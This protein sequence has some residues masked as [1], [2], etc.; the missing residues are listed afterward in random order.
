MAHPG[1]ADRARD[2]CPR[3]AHPVPRQRS[4]RDHVGERGSCV[5]RAVW[6]PSGS[7]LRV[8]NHERFGHRIRV[9]APGRRRGARGDLRPPSGRPHRQRRSGPVARVGW[10][11]PEP[12]SL[13]AGGRP[14]PV[15]RPDRRL[16]P[17]WQAAERGSRRNGDRRRAAGECRPHVGWDWR[18]GD[19]LRRPGARRDRGGHPAST[20]RRADLYR[21]RQALHDDRHRQR[22]GQDRRGAGQCSRRDDPRPGA[23][24]PRRP[25]VPSA[26]RARLV[27][28]TRRPGSR[29]PPRPSPDHVDPRLARGARGCVRGRRPVEA[30]TLLPARRR[31][32]GRR[33]V[34]R[35]SGSSP[36]RG[37]DGRLHPRQDRPPGP[38][39][40][41]LP[42]PHLHEPLL[43]PGRRRMPLRADVPCRR[44]GL[45]RRR[46]QPPH[47]R[48]LAHDHDHRERGP[49]PRV[50]RGVAPDRVARAPRSTPRP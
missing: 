4:T 10:L 16:R 7:A 6:R 8:G 31:V 41:H 9:G 2:R 5:R 47:R 32:D 45:R 50:A 42:R 40:R 33:R 35:G 30:A 36:F 15:R 26:V 13:V 28:A 21:A 1:R 34:A 23:R 29:R 38:R 25:D 12:R 17:G 48:P 27:R 43:E 3:T 39:R 44:D 49:G 20:R 46:D 37:S 22:P 18:R 11:E 24:R 14:S 19:D